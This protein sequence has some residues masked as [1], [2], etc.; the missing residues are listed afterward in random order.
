[1]LKRIKN[2]QIGIIKA[3]RAKNKPKINKI[4]KT[5]IPNSQDKNLRNLKI[6]SGTSKIMKI[7]PLTQTIRTTS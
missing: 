5:I 1:M 4:V 2:F 3:K 6:A 7:A